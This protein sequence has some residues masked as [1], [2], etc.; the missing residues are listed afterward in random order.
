LRGLNSLSSLN[1]HISAGA[2]VAAFRLYPRHN[3]RV[4]HISLVF[5][6][7]WDTAAVPLKPLADSTTPHG[8]PT[9]APALPGFRTSQFQRQPRVRANLDRKSG[10]RGTKK[11]GEAHHSLSFRTRL[12]CGAN[13]LL[14][15]HPRTN[16]RVP[17]PSRFFA[18]GGIAKSVP[19]TA[20][21]SA[22][23]PWK[24]AASNKPFSKTEP[25]LRG[26]SF[27]LGLGCVLLGTGA[28]RAAG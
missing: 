5:R 26:G 6:E 8:C 2:P 3:G 24:T 27:S 19:S 7:M 22:A 23:P 4:P 21:A 9:F 28:G 15:S 17:H 25:Q 16:R 1:S 14:D 11:M 13:A 18:K 12:E 10:L 20:E